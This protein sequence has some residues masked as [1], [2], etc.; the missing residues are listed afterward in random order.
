MKHLVLFGTQAFAEIAHYYFSHD[1]GYSVSAF[2]VDAPYLK[3]A[4]FKGLPVVA[5]EEVEKDF[6]PDECGMFVAVGIHGVNRL[7]AAKV[8]EAEAKGY[9]LA[10]FVSSR[11]DVA[12][13]LELR[14]NTMI[15]ERAGIQPF[16]EIGRNTVIWSATRIGFHTRIG[17]H[18]WIVCPI[19][20]ES[21]S[22][23]DYSFIG[24]NATIAPHVSIG[25]GNVIGAGALILKDTQDFEVYRGHPSTPSQVPS[26][27]MWAF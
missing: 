25:K 7:R 1:S 22:I 16:V 27:R 10:S 8:A 9:Q 18:C 13:D 15:M 20:G 23:G 2:T 19:F 14:P 5:F 4:T 17:D 21:V 6:P 24:L 11:A 3:E 12:P 26:N